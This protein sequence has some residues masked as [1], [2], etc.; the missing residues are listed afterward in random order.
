MDTMLPYC[1]VRKM[2][3]VDILEYIN[4]QSFLIMSVS[5]LQARPFNIV[6]SS[7]RHYISLC[8]HYHAVAY[9]CR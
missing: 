9:T 1:K 4:V 5:P 7:H 3:G 8:I 6:H 2:R